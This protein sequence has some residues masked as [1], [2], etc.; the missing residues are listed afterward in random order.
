[1]EYLIIEKGKIKK[2]CCGSELPK[3]AI[4]VKNFSGFVGESV[5][6]YYSD[7]T[8][9]SDLV[10]MQEGLKD[11][12]Q[13]Y[14]WNDDESELVQMTQIE[15]IESGLEEMPKGF[16]IENNELVPMTD[17]EM[18]KEGLLS[19]E[20]YSAIKRA[21]RDSLLSATDKYLLSD[22][23]IDEERLS[24]IKLYRQ[25]LRDLPQQ[26]GF[27]DIEIPKLQ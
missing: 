12:P 25:T 16:K 7:W 11:I 23:P 27:P 6:F 17:S 22:Y 4:E 21:E 15:K 8:R 10:L 19:K 26:K 14:K 2:H 5:D 24:E 3:G 18:Y 9:K 20:G 13:G 1:M